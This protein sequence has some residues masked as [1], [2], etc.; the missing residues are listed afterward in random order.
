VTLKCS[1]PVS[2][3][4]GLFFRS[5]AVHIPRDYMVTVTATGYCSQ[6]A[7]LTQIVGGMYLR[8][9]PPRLCKQPIN[10]RLHRVLESGDEKG[11]PYGQKTQPAI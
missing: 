9:S 11:T 10:I 3:R 8:S 4:R 6:C 7:P 5:S 2:E 1:F